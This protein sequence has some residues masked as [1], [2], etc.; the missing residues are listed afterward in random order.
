[1]LYSLNLL[2][3][4][5]YFSKHTCC[6]WL[7]WSHSWATRTLSLELETLYHSYT[8]AFWLF[9]YGI[10]RYERFQVLGISGTSDADSII[11]TSTQLSMYL[12]PNNASV[13]SQVRSYHLCRLTSSLIRKIAWPAGVR[14]DRGNWRRNNRCIGVDTDFVSEVHW[15]W[16]QTD[17]WHTG[18]IY[19]SILVVVERVASECEEADGN[20]WCVYESSGGVIIIVTLIDFIV[21]RPQHWKQHRLNQG[22][23]LRRQ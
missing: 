20:L 14:C 6:L 9:Y 21:Y 23:R 15:P 8:Y 1:M 5:R 10:N 7:G 11:R 19:H 16:G 2:Y 13:L 4:L 22:A 17:H 18:S 12:Q 3:L